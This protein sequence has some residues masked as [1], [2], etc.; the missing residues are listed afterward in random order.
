MPPA[1]RSQ[2]VTTATGELFLPSRAIYRILD[3]EQ[4]RLRFHSLRCLNPEPFRGRWTWNYEHEAKALGF[5]SAYDALPPERQPVVLATC[6]VIDPSTLHVYVRCTDRLIKALKFFDLHFPSNFLKGE[7]LDEYNLVTS[8]SLDGP[9]SLPTPEA[10]FQ[11]ESRIQLRDGKHAPA[12]VKKRELIPSERHRLD[13][14]YEDGPEY[15]NS[16]MQIRELLAM[17]QHESANPIRPYEV[18]EKMLRG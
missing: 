7:F 16:A 11:D 10:F 4:V 2:I 12:D 8:V 6:Y 13:T 5:P 17:K 1:P 9:M 15:L 14:Y 18:I 3:E